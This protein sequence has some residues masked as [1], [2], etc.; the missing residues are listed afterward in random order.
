MTFIGHIMAI[1]AQKELPAFKMN[2][3]DAANAAKHVAKF[4]EMFATPPKLST[5]D[6]LQHMEPLALTEG[7]FLS[8]F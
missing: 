6:F 1:E 7:Q 8:T 3:S 5:C 4:A 2:G